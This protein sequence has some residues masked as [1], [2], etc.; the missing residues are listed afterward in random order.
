MPQ[1]PSTMSAAAINV[2]G[3]NRQ[4]LDEKF[5]DNR[6]ELLSTVR[7]NFTPFGVVR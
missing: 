6:S 7:I 5:K 4:I 1:K 2:Q 3:L